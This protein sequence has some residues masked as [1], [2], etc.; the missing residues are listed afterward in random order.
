MPDL[1][2][3]KDFD[4]IVNRLMVGEPVDPDDLV[5]L[6]AAMHESGISFTGA[7]VPIVASLPPKVKSTLADAEIRAGGARAIDRYNSRFGSS[8]KESCR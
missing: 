6:A 4:R 5:K 3:P 1:K 8:A 2:L 7:S